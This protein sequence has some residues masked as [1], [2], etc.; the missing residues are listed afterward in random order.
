VHPE[1]AAIWRFPWDSTAK[2]LKLCAHVEIKAG[3]AAH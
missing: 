1:I 2:A 3:G